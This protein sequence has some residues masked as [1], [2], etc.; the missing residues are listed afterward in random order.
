M[1]WFDMI[2]TIQY[3]IDHNRKKLKFNSIEDISLRSEEFDSVIKSIAQPRELF[4]KW[5]E[6]SKPD[7]DGI[8]NCIT[9][10]CLDDRREV[11]LYTA[12]RTFP[13]YLSINEERTK[14]TQI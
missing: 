1:S 4:S 12:G 13:L 3:Q 2:K 5:G 11:V 9:L 14:L 10:K 6:K 7:D 8:W